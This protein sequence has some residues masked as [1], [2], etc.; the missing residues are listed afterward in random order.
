M[1]MNRITTTTARRPTQRAFDDCRT[2][3]AARSGD[4]STE[5]VEGGDVKRST[6]AG[7]TAGRGTGSRCSGSSSEPLSG[8]SVN[9][10]GPSDAP[11]RGAR[12]D[13]PGRSERDGEWP[14]GDLARVDG[15]HAGVVHG[16]RESVHR[17][18]RGAEGRHVPLD[19]EPVI[20]RPVTGALELEVLETRVGLAAEVRT[21]LV[22]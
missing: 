15:Q 14:E 11:G 2:T 18:R 16:D 4:S 21:A 3:C 1:V 17:A 6:G 12:R 19:P 22:E 9:G 7:S 13:E 10:P 8:V 5:R 20:A